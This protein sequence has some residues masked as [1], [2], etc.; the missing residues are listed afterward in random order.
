MKERKLLDR[1]ESRG[2]GSSTFVGREDELKILRRAWISTRS[3]KGRAIELQGDPGIGKS[4][5]LKQFC[6]DHLPQGTS[7]AQY[8]CSSHYTN[9]AF[10]PFIQ[11]IEKVAGVDAARDNDQ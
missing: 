2:G 8:Q 11:Q 6:E 5:L 1:F 3:G 7:I 10:H 9:S 4:R